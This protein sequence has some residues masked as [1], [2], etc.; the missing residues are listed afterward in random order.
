MPNYAI[1]LS[2]TAEAWAALLKHPQDRSAAVAKTVDK[3]GGKI[4]GFWLSFGNHDLVG[5]VE[6]PDNA[7]AAAFSMAV[8]A[9][10]ACHNIAT[11][12]LMTVPEAI[13]AMKKAATCGYKPVTAK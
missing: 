6:F 8:A 13:E 4:T 2:Y 9:G 5:I 7:A 12:P 1:T 3:L 11:H 10:G